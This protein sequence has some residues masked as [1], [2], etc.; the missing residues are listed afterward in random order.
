MQPVN[1][2]YQ[3]FLCTKGNTIVHY[4]ILSNNR[5]K[6][7][8][9]SSTYSLGAMLLYDIAIILGPG[10]TVNP[11]DSD[12][13]KESCSVPSAEQVVCVGTMNPSPGGLKPSTRRIEEHR[14]IGMS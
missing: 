10:T 11:P 9:E 4:T 8:R 1:D 6:T 12:D 13:T 5:P 2:C 3:A 14:V 7:F